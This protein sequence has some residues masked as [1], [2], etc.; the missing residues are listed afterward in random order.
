[1]LRIENEAVPEG[2]D[3]VPQQEEFGSGQ[4]TL[5]EVCWVIEVA[6]N[7]I[8]LRSPFFAFCTPKSRPL[9]QSKNKKRLNVCVNEMALFGPYAGV[10]KG[11]TFFISD[12]SKGGLNARRDSGPTGYGCASH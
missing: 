2:N 7:T 1:M 6:I 3:S 5:E 11:K 4:P 12:G 8:V 10:A 9:Q